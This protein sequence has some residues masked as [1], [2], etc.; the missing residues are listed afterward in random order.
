MQKE[1]K[2]IV[3][4]KGCHSRKSL[5]GTY[6]ACSFVKKQQTAYV[7]DP[8]TLRAAT[9]SGMT[10]LLNNT[11]SSVPTGHLPPHGEAAHFNA[12]STWRERAECVSTG[13]RGNITRGFTL[14]ELLVV[15][16]II[17]ILAAVALPQYQKVV[18]RARYQQLVVMGRKIAQAQA[19]YYLANG[20]YTFTFDDLDLSFG[21]YSSYYSS[22][23]NGTF[24]VIKWNTEQC[25]LRSYVAT[26]DI[27]C[28]S[29]AANVPAFQMK[30]NS[31]QAF[32]FAE[33]ETL[34]EK[35]CQLET[36]A[37]AVPNGSYNLYYY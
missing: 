27:Q 8:R 1:N 9:F 15:V 18:A 13:G 12:P 20:K 29:Y 36:G 26:P 21:K 3:L 10:T 17:G 35:I 31:Q 5:S 19:V 32:C 7:E 37:T 30:F 2:T 11:P 24:E 4:S 22:N 16:L 34:A 14:I 28:S 6:D 25:I 23:G 33:K